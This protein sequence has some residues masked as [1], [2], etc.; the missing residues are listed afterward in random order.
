MEKFWEERLSGK[1]LD[2]KGLSLSVRGRGEESIGKTEHF[3][4][5]RPERGNR[6]RRRGSS[7]CSM[8][9]G[10]V[11]RKRDGGGEVSGGKLSLGKRGGKLVEVLESGEQSAPWSGA[12]SAAKGPIDLRIGKDP[13]RKMTRGKR[14]KK[15]PPPGFKCVERRSFARKGDARERSEG[16]EDGGKKVL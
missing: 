13:G 9:R 15:I 16:R 2:R 5:G 8:I 10:G 14:Q 1:E 7:S 4:R 3:K 11:R 6:P 12:F